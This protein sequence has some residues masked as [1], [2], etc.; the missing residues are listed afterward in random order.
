ME[1]NLEERKI[2]GQKNVTINEQFFQ[3]HFPDAP[4]MP[5]VLL[6][7]A[8]AQ[9]GGILAHL[10]GKD[11]GK[12]AVLLKIDEAKFRSP[13]KPGDIVHLHCHM[14]HITTKAGKTVGEAKVGD[15][16]VASARLVLHSLI[17][18]KCKE[19]EMTKI[20]YPSDS[21]CRRGATFGEGVVIEP[22]AIVK[23]N[24]VF[25]DRVVI[26]SHA[27]IDGYTTI[28]EG[29]IIYP[30]RQYW[31]QDPGLEIPRREDIS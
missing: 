23:K 19:I 17:K 7:E 29:T 8:L 3:G 15:R 2:V 21:D 1:V 6:L 25:G 27:Y 10:L 26:K 4:I 22:Y 30:R 13:V 14:A 16:V 20:E 11:Q 12:I 18:A 5:G 9:T 31:H 24:V 28:G